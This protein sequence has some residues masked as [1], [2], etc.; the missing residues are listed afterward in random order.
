MLSVPA[1]VAPRTGAR[2][3]T[4]YAADTNKAGVVES[5][6]ARGRGLKLILVA[7]LASGCR[8]APRTGARIETLNFS[9]CHCLIV[10]PR[11][12]ARIETVAAPGGGRGSRSPPARGRGLKPRRPRPDGD[13]G[14]LWSPPARG[15]GLKLA[16]HP[17]SPVT[18]LQSPPARG[19]GL[20][21]E[22][23][24]STTSSPQSCRPPHGGA[25]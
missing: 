20:K 22:L 10:A 18:C 14:H 7:S 8:V 11:T 2:I 4:R 25:D 23:P 1:S 24:R 6:P 19:R 3:E 13:R 21:Q 9:G 17:D 16:G 15:R 12:G 5:P